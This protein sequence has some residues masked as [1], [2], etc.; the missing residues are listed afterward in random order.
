MVYL[1]RAVSPLLAQGGEEEGLLLSASACTN[2][3]PASSFSE[4]CVEFIQQHNNS[5]IKIKIT[6][7]STTLDCPVKK[8]KNTWVMGSFGGRCP[9]IISASVAAEGMD[10]ILMEE[11]SERRKKGTKGAAVRSYTGR[12]GFHLIARSKINAKYYN[13]QKKLFLKRSF[14]KNAF[15]IIIHHLCKPNTKQK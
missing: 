15:L 11:S 12:R 14:E 1:E 6:H 4:L 9:T 8:R 5:T 2:P 7:D 13:S 10:C 3:W